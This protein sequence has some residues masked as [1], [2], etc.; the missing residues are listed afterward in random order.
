MKTTRSDKIKVELQLLTG[1]ITDDINYM[2]YL[3]LK[4]GVYF[5]KDKNIEID[6]T[7]EKEKIAELSCE[8]LDDYFNSL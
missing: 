6:D 5:N 1:V 3:L 4:D 2:C 7:R 8:S